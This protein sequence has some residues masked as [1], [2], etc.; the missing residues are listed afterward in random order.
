MTE[1]PYRR[2]SCDRTFSRTESVLPPPPP[3]G[4]HAGHGLPPQPQHPRRRGDQH[5]I[6]SLG[7]LFLAL[8]HPYPWLGL[9][10][11]VGNRGGTLDAGAEHNG[12]RSVSRRQLKI[13]LVLPVKS[14][15]NTCRQPL[16][17]KK[18]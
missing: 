11:D 7:S 12:K 18:Y 14:I 16:Y 17:L 13:V 5:I 2:T 1:Y 6:K 10:G 9:A 4:G 15:K 3:P 8:H